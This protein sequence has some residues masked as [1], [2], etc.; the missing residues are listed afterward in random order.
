MGECKELGG[1]FA[2]QKSVTVLQGRTSSSNFN[3]ISA[4][5]DQY[6]YWRKTILLCKGK[7]NSSNHDRQSAVIP[8]KQ[9]DEFI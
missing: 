7:P 5:A 6:I 3:L 1:H 8:A 2:L 9:P 4:V